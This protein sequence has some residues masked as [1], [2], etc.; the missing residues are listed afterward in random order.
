[1]AILSPGTLAL[2]Q[3]IFSSL[4]MENTISHFSFLIRMTSG[5]FLAF[6]AVSA[7][8]PNEISELDMSPEIEEAFYLHL[9]EVLARAFSTVVGGSLGVCPGNR[10]RSFSCLCLACSSCSMSCFVSF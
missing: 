1:M 8:Y 4:N 6:S 10:L 9:P 7:V 3:F 5:I 2:T